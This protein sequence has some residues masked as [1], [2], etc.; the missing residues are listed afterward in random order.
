MSIHLKSMLLALAAPVVFG[1]LA[2]NI[3]AQSTG[4]AAFAAKQEIKNQVL[5]A[6]S[7]GK[8][9]PNERRDILSHAKDKLSANE[10]VGLVNTL[11][12]L[13]PPDR[14]VPE[15]LGYTPAVDKQLMAN[16]PAPDLT[17]LAKSTLG[18]TLSNQ[19]LVK[20]IM[21]KQNVCCERDASQADLYCKRDNYQTDYC[22]S[23]AS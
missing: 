9:T 12:R 6:M 1:L 14:S 3:A 15:D 2:S 13:S 8:I 5:A 10:Y 16:F 19:S 4:P 17:R 23:R 22:G 21:P 18:E 11:N 20:A 7:D